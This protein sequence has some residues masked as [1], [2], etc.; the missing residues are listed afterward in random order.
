MKKRAVSWTD[1][2]YHNAF[3]ALDRNGD[4]AIESGKELFGDFTQQL[5]SK[6]P[7]GFRALAWFDFPENGGNGDGIIDDRDAVWAS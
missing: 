6:D 2:R 4:G 3:L 7:N 1:P 5:P